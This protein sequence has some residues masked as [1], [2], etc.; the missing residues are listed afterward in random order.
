M[1]DIAGV[2]SASVG[3][4]RAGQNQEQQQ[5]VSL[6]QAQKDREGQDPA[7]RRI[8]EAQ[9]GASANT[10]PRN[11]TPGVSPE[12]R[13]RDDINAKTEQK[14]ARDADTKAEIAAQ[15]RADQSSVKVTLSEAA[16]RAQDNAS[17]IANKDTEISRR[18]SADAVQSTRAELDSREFTRIID[19]NRQQPDASKG[20][21]SAGR[22]L[23]RVVDRFA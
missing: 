10:D 2:G 9:K 6:Q 15:E 11:L 20:Q 16:Q 23:G 17:R 3:A 4:L 8:E 14:F 7:E 1:T 13:R 18:K 12:A 19:E 21:S 5:Q 22:Q